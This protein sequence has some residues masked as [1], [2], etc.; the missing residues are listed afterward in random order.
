MKN[1]LLILASVAFNVGAQLLLKKGVQAFGKLDLSLQTVAQ[2]FVSIFTNAYI[3]SGM[4]CFVLSAFLWLYV[5]SKIPVSIAYPLGSLGYIFT[6]VLAY[7]LLNEPL[8]LVKIIGILLI[9][10]G[11]AILTKA[12]SG[13]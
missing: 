10:A 12:S 1:I 2:L 4:L 6:A 9:C 5:L 3:F 7:F 11:V 8:S 13:F